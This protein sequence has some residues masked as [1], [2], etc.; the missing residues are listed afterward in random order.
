MQTELNW[1]F[2]KALP[3]E[4]TSFWFQQDLTQA[5]PTPTQSPIFYFP[6]THFQL[7]L[8]EYNKEN[9]IFPC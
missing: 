9:G 1:K 4:L 6:S 8:F 2:F 7:C 3:K 5:A